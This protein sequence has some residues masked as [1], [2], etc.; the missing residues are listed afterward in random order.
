[1]SLVTLLCGGMK[2]GD[3]PLLSLRQHEARP[4]DDLSSLLNYF[5]Q[6]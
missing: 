4:S 6:R 2:I 5:R 1:M 3:L